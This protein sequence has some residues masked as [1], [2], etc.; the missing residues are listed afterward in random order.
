MALNMMKNIWIEKGFNTF[1][2]IKIFRN[3]KDIGLNKL[4]K[5]LQGGLSNWLIL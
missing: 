5:S 2:F 4:N 1:V 3:Y